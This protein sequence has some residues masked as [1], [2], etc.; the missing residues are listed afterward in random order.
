MNLRLFLILSF[1]AFGSS[2]ARAESCVGY[3]DPPPRACIGSGGCDTAVP[4][5]RCAIG[6]VAGTCNQFGNSA[7]CCGVAVSYAQIF[8]NGDTCTGANCGLSQIRL[9]RSKRQKF[10]EMYALAAPP[11]A[12][13]VPLRRIFTLNTCTHDYAVVYEWDGLPTQKQGI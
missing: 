8:S 12:L 1:I 3:F 11:P 5:T 7:S 4:T 10:E 13:R 9:A 2:L 6:C